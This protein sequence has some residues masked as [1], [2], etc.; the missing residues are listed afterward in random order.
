MKYSGLGGEAVMEGVMMRHGSDYAIAVRKPDQEIEVKVERGKGKGSPSD[1]MWMK[2]PVVRGVISFINSLVV[3]MSTLMYSASFFED[4][5]EEEEEKEKKRRREKKPVDPAK[6]EKREKAMM[7]GVLVFSLVIAVAA[8]ILLPYYLSMLFQRFV[9]DNANLVAVFEGVLRLVIFIVYIWFI[10]RMED[11]QRLFMYH[12]AEHKCINCVENGLDLTVDNVRIS[13]R[14]HRRCGTSFLVFVV[15]I[16]IILYLFIRVDSHVLRIVIRIALIP[17]VAGLAFEL[18][19]AAGR[20]D[21]KFIQIISKPGMWVQR[22]TV[23]EPDDSMI[24]VGIASVE[25]VFDWRPFVEE[26][27]MEESGEEEGPS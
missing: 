7:G 4:E 15:I 10:S 22:L 17:V 12:G 25:A 16:S 11:I 24:E 19:R 5:E 9:T 14:E 6:E 21:N 3:D 23:K 20:T 18:L 27:R 2:I 1:K 8:F 13:S 26:I